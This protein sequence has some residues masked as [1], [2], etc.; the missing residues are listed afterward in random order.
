M[1]DYENKSAQP[2]YG[3]K[4][5]GSVLVNE[6]PKSARYH[7]DRANSIVFASKRLPLQPVSSERN[8]QVADKFR[9]VSCL[10]VYGRKRGHVGVKQC[11][12][13]FHSL[14]CLLSVFFDDYMSKLFPIFYLAN[15]VCFYPSKYKAFPPNINY[16][17]V[18]MYICMYMYVRISMYVYVRTYIYV[19]ICMYVYMYVYMYIYICIYVYIYIYM[20]RYICI[21]A[22]EKC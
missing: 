4:I 17:F 14:D 11:M 16:I 2:I 3:C 22:R 8:H 1:V 21:D 15:F 9:K 5:Y 20:Y 6:M 7:I 10:N 12:H 13:S 18:Y 19:C